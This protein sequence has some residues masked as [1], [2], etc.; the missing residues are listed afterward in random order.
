MN[1]CVKMAKRHFHWQLTPEV[2]TTI[3]QEKLCIGIFP[4]MN[5]LSLLGVTSG[6]KTVFRF[7]KM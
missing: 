5:I 6:Y 2:Y 7:V 4:Y 3:S 1:V